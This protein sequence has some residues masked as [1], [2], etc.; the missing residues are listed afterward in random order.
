MDIGESFWS[1]SVNQYS[2]ALTA[3][4]ITHLFVWFKFVKLDYVVS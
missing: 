2:P 1:V 4:N 3:W